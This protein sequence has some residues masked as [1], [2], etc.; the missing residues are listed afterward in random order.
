MN[1]IFVITLSAVILALALASP[2]ELNEEQK[3]LAKQHGEQC[4]KELNLTEEEIAKVKAKDFKNPTEN[5]KCFANCFFEKIGT[6]KNGEIQEA[7]VLEKLGAFI[8]E[9]KTKAALAKCGSIKGE[10]NCDTA[11]KLHECF[12]EFKPK[13]EIKA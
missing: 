11:V 9:E 6:L 4:S 1:S 2:V 5:I 8:G 12:E 3:A 13:H 7:V 10:N